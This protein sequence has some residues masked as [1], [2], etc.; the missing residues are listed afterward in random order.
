[1]EHKATVVIVEDEKT[2]SNL[3]QAAL[4]ASHYNVVSARNVAEAEAIICSHCP[5]VILL[6]LGLPD[7][8]GLNLIRTVRKWSQVPIIV[9]SARM[10]QGDKVKALDMG[11]DDYITKPFGIQEL[12]ARIRTAIR[13]LRNAGTQD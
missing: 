13:H 12:L 11:A 9:V 10:Q 7:G 1:M 2:I 4:K 6:D 3:L 8:D 5:D